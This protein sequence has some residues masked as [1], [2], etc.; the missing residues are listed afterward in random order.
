LAKRLLRVIKKG[1]HGFGTPAV[2]LTS[3]CTILGAIMFLRFG[4]AVGHLGY[5][6]ALW[7]VILGHLITIPTGLA[8]SEIATNLKVGGGGEYYIIS[9]SFGTTIGASIGVMLYSSQVISVAF[10]II[11]FAEIFKA[12]FF[13]YTGDMINPVVSIFETY[14][15]LPFSAWMVSLAAVLILGGIMIKRGAKIGI[16]ALWGIF[17]L[18]LAAVAVFLLGSP[19]NGGGGGNPFNN[20]DEPLSFP[21]V[22]AIIFPAFTG[23]TAGVGLSGD[24]KNPRKSIPNGIILAIA[25]GFIIYILVITKLYM[26]ASPEELVANQHVMYE[27]ALWGPLVLIGLAAATISSAIGSILIAPRTLQAIANDKI[28]PNERANTFLGKGEGKENEPKNATYISITIAV[29]FVLLG[30][31]NLVASFITMFFLITYGSVCMISFLEHFAGNPS[32]RPTFRTWWLLSLIGALLSFYMMFWISPFYAILAIIIMIIIYKTNQIAHRESRSFAVIFQGVM[33]QLSR[34]MKIILQK[35]G[36]IPD[37]FNW[38]PSVIAI[39]SHAVD[40][41]APKDLLRWISKYYGFGTMIHYIKGR[42]DRKS[43]KTSKKIQQELVDQINV[44]KA[45]YSVSTVVSPS[46]RTAVAQVVQFTGIAGLD[47]NTI[48]FEYNQYRDEELEEIVDGCRLVDAVRYNII[49]LRST[50]HNFGFKERIHIWLTRDDVKN[51]NLMILL[52]FI[53]MAHHEWEN[54]KIT[55]YTA[56]P[57]SKQEARLSEIKHLIQKGRLPITLKNVQSFTYTDKKSLDK[58]I[59][60]KSKNADLVIVGF[61]QKQLEKFGVDVFKQHEKLRETLF[62]SAG[63]RIYIS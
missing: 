19:L 8:L 33:F 9:R 58:L 47:N 21:I 2:F 7:V 15:G 31:L 13:I 14:T 50:E 18:L 51:G 40:R 52:S 3:I 10:Y 27:I 63:E 45:N 32:Y 5:I 61:T 16:K 12:D 42:L 55:I 17:I 60:R 30:D 59:Y 46:L 6:M 41:A 24:L 20:V 37:K 48:L 54:A 62:I 29:I 43:V 39:S 11:A 4:F 25:T 28:M 34:W 35:S 26:S 49:V 44:S 38:R 53:I 36:S 22:F 23:M 57:E 56:F 1:G